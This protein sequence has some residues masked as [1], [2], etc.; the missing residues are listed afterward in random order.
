MNKYIN[1]ANDFAYKLGVTVEGAIARMDEIG[2]SWYGENILKRDT[3]R[4]CDLYFTLA[5]LQHPNIKHVLEI[6]AGS[7]RATVLLARL[8]PEANIWTFDIPEDDPNF[9][10]IGKKEGDREKIRMK[11]QVIKNIT[12]FEKNS[13]YLSSMNFLPDYFDLIFID[14]GHEYPAIAWDLSYSYGHL[15][16]DGFLFIHDYGSRP[17]VKEAVDYMAKRIPEKI[18]YL[19]STSAETIKAKTPCIWR[20]HK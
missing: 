14:G 8:F 6:G 15:A 19:P 1:E 2:Y 18:H 5:S 16:V 7:G 13:F 9:K 3:V 4:L 11:L 17:N 10:R 12:Y 20:G